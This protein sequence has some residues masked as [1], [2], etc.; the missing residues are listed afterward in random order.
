MFILVHNFS[1]TDCGNDTLSCGNGLCIP[2][3]EKCDGV[4]HC[5]NGLDESDMYCGRLG[6]PVISCQKLP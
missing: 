3:I 6:V 2:L 5:G 4:D 1:A